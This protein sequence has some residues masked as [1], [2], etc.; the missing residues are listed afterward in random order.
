MVCAPYFLCGR[1][2][3]PWSPIDECNAEIKDDRSRGAS[4]SLLTLV[5]V[6]WGAHWSFHPSQA[7]FVTVVSGMLCLPL[8][9][10][11][12][13][14]QGMSWIWGRVWWPD[15]G[16]PFLCSGPGIPLR[17]LRAPPMGC[18]NTV[19]K[20]SNSLPHGRCLSLSTRGQGR[21]CSL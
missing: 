2:G 13:A 15:H 17:S 4:V 19:G 6:C 11:L 3:T 16:Q 12:A 1:V 10:T 5:T 21:L 7:F 14:L 20:E 8:L 18:S 9:L